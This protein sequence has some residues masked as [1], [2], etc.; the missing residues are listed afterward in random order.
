MTDKL[1]PK[2]QLYLS[3][4]KY[5]KHELERLR[6]S[7]S[8]RVFVSVPICSHI[9]ETHSVLSAFLFIPLADE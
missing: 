1:Q 9:R 6:G 4:Q 3:T 2:Q 7:A 5:E 8:V